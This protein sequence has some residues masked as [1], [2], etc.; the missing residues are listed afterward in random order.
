MDGIEKK[1]LTNEEI[2]R[3]LMALLKQNNMQKQA[4]DTFEIC[5]YVD[6][7]EKK[8]EEM[9]E[10][11]ANVQ[12]QLKDMK[13]DT[14]IN[15]AKKSLNEAKER[16]QTQVNMMKTKLFEVKTEITTKATFIVNET[17]KKGR[18]A[19]LKVHEIFKIK[20]KLVVIREKVKESQKTVSVTIGKIDAFGQGMREA[21]QK[22]ANTFRT[23]ADKPEVDYTDKEKKF[24]KTELIKKPWQ[25]KLKLL[26]AMELRLDA[27]IDKVE[28]LE[29]DVEIDRMEQ[30][31]REAPKA[32]NKKSFELSEAQI[33]PF[34]MVA[35]E[36]QYGAEA[37]EAYQSKMDGKQA[38]AADVVKEVASVKERKGR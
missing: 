3:E 5:A 24:S 25:A 14:F 7:L 31:E 6:S 32:E 10:E 28:N 11:L 36:H 26:K 19:L 8:L 9:T 17:K 20:E 4:N 18:V 33:M 16:V 23:F 2:I 13:E 37:F 30:A 15:N 35:E 22:I 12:Q 34:A 29:R 27:A 1:Q 21:G 38:Q